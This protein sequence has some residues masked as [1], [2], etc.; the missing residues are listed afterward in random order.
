MAT[1]YIIVFGKF[2]GKITDFSFANLT[3]EELDQVMIGYLM[4]AI[5][6]FKDCV[7]SLSDRDNTIMQFTAD[8]TDEELE[9]LGTLM[10]VEW[11]TPQINSTSLVNQA[12]GEKDFRM[13]S[14]ANHL[15]SLVSLKS[16][17]MVEADDLIMRYTFVR[18]DIDEMNRS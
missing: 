1:P 13:T 14:Q 16:S 3:D 18:D 6:K 8:L 2:L 7:Q 9:I 15:D 5:P 10:V 4:S 11:L 17:M 12:I